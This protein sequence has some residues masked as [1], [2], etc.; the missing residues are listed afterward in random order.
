M[1]VAK[2]SWRTPAGEE[3]T[4]WVVRYVDQAGRRRLKTFKHKKSADAF[5]A[6]TAVEVREG[7]H[8]PDRA[9]ITIAEAGKLWIAE[10]K[11]SGL[12]R[13]TIDQRQQHLDLHLVP[14]IGARKLSAINGP[15]VHAFQDQLRAAGRSPAMVKRVTTSL[16][17]ILA[18]AQSQ[19][20]VV[21]NAVRD[22]SRNRA[23]RDS[24]LGKRQKARLRVGVDIP[25]NAEIR[26][27]IAAAT[28]RYRPL[29]I[30]AIFTGMRASELRGLAWHDVDLDRSTVTVSQRAD[31]YQD[32]GAPKSTSGRRTIPLPPSAVETLK[33]WRD[34]CPASDKGL[35]F[36][37]GA[38]KVE[39][40]NNMLQR[41]LWPAQVAAGVVVMEDGP[42]GKPVPRA[43]YKGFHALRHWF[44]SWCIN[45]RV[46]GGLELTAK[47]VQERMGHGS[48]AVTLDTYSHLFPAVD[49]RQAL[50]AA[51]QALLGD[52][53]A[54]SAP[55]AP[56][57]HAAE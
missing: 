53:S 37:N 11:A 36:P 30:V 18:E 4:A 54:T 48:I 39:Y 46:D 43:R 5:A 45:R 7:T 50:E 52:M 8:V 33:A 1:S 19:G 35:V 20:L 51:E 6:T 47:A 25:T 24:R 49:E 16:G 40:H 34:E 57:M 10:G 9:T 17:S 13:T 26:K 21:R 15:T 32:I 55:D 12:E 27:I 56:E 22:M 3:R 42:D 38:G 44:A 23:R 14:F 31:R 2:R 28:G 29:L 41:G